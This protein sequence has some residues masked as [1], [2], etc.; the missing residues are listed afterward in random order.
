MRSVSPVTR[1][2]AARP[3]GKP[4]V[5][6]LPALIRRRVP[7]GTHFSAGEP[8]SGAGI[9]GPCRV[10]PELTRRGRRGPP[11]LYLR[12]L[13][14]VGWSASA[15]D[16]APADALPAGRRHDCGRTMPVRDAIA[17]PHIC[18]GGQF[19]SHGH[20]RHWATDSDTVTSVLGSKFWV[21]T[22]FG[23][24]T[25]PRVKDLATMSERPRLWGAHAP[26]APMMETASLVERALGGIS[27]V[28]QWSIQMRPIVRLS[29]PTRRSGWLPRSRES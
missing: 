2:G 6:S 22:F 21:R 13:A 4:L 5:W 26:S 7:F 18:R 24:I 3:P 11:G 16:H 12:R 17:D 28:R 1:C 19:G 9:V 29:L 23:V 8:Q 15:I 27:S 14:R 10:V 20:Y 25:S